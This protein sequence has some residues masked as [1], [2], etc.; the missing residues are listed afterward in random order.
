[1]LLSRPQWIRSRIGRPTGWSCVC[2]R[3]PQSNSSSSHFWRMLMWG[4]AVWRR[5]APTLALARDQQRS[6][7]QNKKSYKS[8]RI[9]IYI[10][11]IYLYVLT[12]ILVTFYFGKKF[13]SQRT[14]SSLWLHFRDQLW[15]TC[16]LNII[17]LMC[18]SRTAINK[19][20]FAWR[21]IP[22]MMS[23]NLLSFPH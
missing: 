9:F 6:S 3:W 12:L 1:M 19:K 23:V 18:F 8:Y 22:M 13:S 16:A 5:G 7:K 2:G 17:E 15:F 11:C 21:P 20:S 4:L 10:Y 14:L